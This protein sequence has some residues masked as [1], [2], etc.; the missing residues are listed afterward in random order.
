MFKVGILFLNMYRILDY[1]KDKVLFSY[2]IIEE[3][4]VI[5]VM[6][7]V[8]VMFFILYEVIEDD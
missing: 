2:N 7:V 3:E 1:F 8:I 5:F 4:I 6:I